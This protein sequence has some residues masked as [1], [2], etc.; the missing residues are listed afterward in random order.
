VIFNKHLILVAAALVLAALAIY[1]YFK[2]RQPKPRLVVNTCLQDADGLRP[3]AGVR[4]AG[5][6]VGYARVVRARP[7]DRDCPAAVE[8]AFT[9]DYEL[10]IPRDSV[11]STATAGVLGGTF[12]EIDISAASAPPIENGGQLP[13]RQREKLSVDKIIELLHKSEAKNAT[14]SPGSTPPPKKEQKTQRD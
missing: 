12:V 4:I 8:L 2:F 5:V 1:A 6:D 14:A 3:G 13:S 7:Q 9:T 10:K 11:A